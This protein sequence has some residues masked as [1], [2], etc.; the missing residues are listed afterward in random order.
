[1]GRLANSESAI[2]IGGP[3]LGRFLIMSELAPTN[4]PRRGFFLGTFPSPSPHQR[5]ALFWHVTAERIVQPKGE[6]LGNIAALN[7][8]ERYYAAPSNH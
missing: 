7:E 6:S 8:N 2:N 3:S 1:M 4:L 5:R